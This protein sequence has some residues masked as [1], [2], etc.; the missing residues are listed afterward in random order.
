ML[1]Q[2]FRVLV[3]LEPGKE[4]KDRAIAGKNHPIWPDESTI[5]S[6]ISQSTAESPPE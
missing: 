1:L 4:G 5:F 6:E 2:P 3:T